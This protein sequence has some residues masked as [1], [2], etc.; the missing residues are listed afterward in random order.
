MIA[1]DPEGMVALPEISSDDPV[2]G[3]F[4]AFFVQE[5]IEAKRLRIKRSRHDF[6][7]AYSLSEVRS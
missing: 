6:F 2:A 3:E 7:K 1:N 4:A 5:K